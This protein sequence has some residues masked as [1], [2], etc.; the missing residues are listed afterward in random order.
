MGWGEAEW[1]LAECVSAG[2]FRREEDPLDFLAQLDQPLKSSSEVLC[3]CLRVISRG[4][5]GVRALLGPQ[6]ANGTVEAQL[7]VL[8]SCLWGESERI[9]FW[10]CWCV[11]LGHAFPSTRLSEIIT[12]EYI[13][14]PPPTVQES[15]CTVVHNKVNSFLLHYF[16]STEKWICGATFGSSSRMKPVH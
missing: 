6:V 8:A 15:V 5:A 7:S 14:G 9:T 12:W 10:F 2:R 3:N 11:S 16:V 1:P 4:A 13:P